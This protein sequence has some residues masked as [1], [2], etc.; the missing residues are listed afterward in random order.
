MLGVGANKNKTNQPNQPTK[1]QLA[2]DSDA[3][4]MGNKMKQRK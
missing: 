4:T 3:D 2:C 1:T